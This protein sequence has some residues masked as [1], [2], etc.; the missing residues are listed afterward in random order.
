[1]SAKQTERLHALLKDAGGF[2]ISAETITARLGMTRVAARVYD[3]RKSGVEIES[4]FVGGQP[5]KS[6]RLKNVPTPI[7]PPAAT[8]EGRLFDAPAPA[9]SHYKDAA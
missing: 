9:T 8:D 5:F 2:W 4:K 6:Y 7:A 3:L 1:M